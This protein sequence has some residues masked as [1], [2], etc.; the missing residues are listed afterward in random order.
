MIYEKKRNGK[1]KYVTITEST[2][3]TDIRPTSFIETEFI[4]LS[5]TGILTVK[6]DYA[7]DGP[8]GPAIDTEN[9]II[10]SLVH[11][12]LYQLIRLGLLIPK[13]KYRRQA[14][15]ELFR[16][17]HQNKMI[18]PRKV[19]VWAGVRLLGWAYI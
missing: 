2:Y 14:D 3:Y 7:W 18:L 6:V 1:Y 17:C 19:W 4:T 12:A 10:P 11:D 5:Q 13:R 8:S 16:F 9:F 15:W